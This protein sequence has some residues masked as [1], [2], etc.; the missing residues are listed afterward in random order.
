[1]IVAAVLRNLLWT[2]RYPSFSTPRG[3]FNVGIAQVRIPE[4]PACQVHYPTL[5][6]RGDKLPYVRRQALQGLSDYS[7]QNPSLLGFL[8][9]RNHPCYVNAANVPDSKFPVVI[10]SHGLGGCMEMYTAL[11]QEIASEGFIVVA[12]E[13]GDGSGAYA[14]TAEG[15]PIYYKRPDSS[16]YS[17]T[18]VVTFRKD[19][20]EHRLQE[21]ETVIDHIVSTSTSDG[22]SDEVPYHAFQAADTTKGLHLLGHSFGGSTMVKTKQEL[23]RFKFDSLSVLDCWAFSLPQDTLDKGIHDIPFLSILSDAWLTNPETEQVKEL[24]Q[25]SKQVASF[26]IQ[27]SVHGSFSD[28]VNWMPGV[29]TRKLGLRGQK[30]SKHATI[31]STAQA[32]V[33][34]MQK[35]S[36]Q[37]HKLE[38]IPIENLQNTGAVCLET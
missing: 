8:S 6:T 15:E 13:H 7:G 28:A 16:P 21:L 33:Q 27:D 17:R 20:L 23:P 25:N 9:K 22:R 4:G 24:L 34:H 30:E 1:M 38:P 14:E 29:V 37:S 10:F 3:E 19:F 36:I 26:Y 11:C 35:K 2:L 18:K 31:R 32:C 12:V 5:E